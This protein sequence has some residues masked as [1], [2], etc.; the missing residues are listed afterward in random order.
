MF[1]LALFL[2]GFD[3]EKIGEKTHLGRTSVIHAGWA[4]G[5]S[6]VCHGRGVLSFEA[7]LVEVRGSGAW[8][9]A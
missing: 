8:G 7:P 5:N 1:E 2:L 6:E 3:K 9:L 4:W